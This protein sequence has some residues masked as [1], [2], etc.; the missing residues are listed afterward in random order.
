MRIIY[1]YTYLCKAIQI[2]SMKSRLNLTIEEPLLEAVKKYANKQNTSV[3]ELVENYFRA[4]IKN[5]KTQS[6]TQLVEELPKQNIPEGIDLM[7]LYYQ[8]KIKDNNNEL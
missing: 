3:S 5:K 6:F 1:Y 7:E 2:Q 4:I 8:F